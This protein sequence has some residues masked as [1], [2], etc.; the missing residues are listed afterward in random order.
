MTGATLDPLAEAADWHVILNDDGVSEADL[1]R[2]RRWLAQSPANASA[3][4]QV[5]AVNRRFAMLQS[6][7]RLDASEAGLRA[8]L[9][10]VSDRRRM[11]MGLAGVG[12][13][14]ALGWSLW[15]DRQRRDIL[16]ARMADERTGTGEL[17]EL[18]LAR[19]GRVWLNS[20]TA[21]DVDG[22]GRLR[23][24]TGE[25]QVLAMVMDTPLRT[26]SRHG[27]IETRGGRFN[28][29]LDGDA[30]RLDVLE[31][32]ALVAIGEDRRLVRSGR[33]LTLTADGYGA[34]SAANADLVAWT[35][36][37]LIARHM[38]LLTLVG[39]LARHS[40]HQLTL[41]PAVANIEIM[42]VYPLQNVDAALDML[43]DA[44]PISI[45]RDRA[46]RI[47]IGPA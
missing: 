42:G 37:M 11:L 36:G 1:S 9:G 31:G 22:G 20:D 43:E 10:A 4:S 44:L 26:E 40:R 47:Y 23:L 28:L 35:R 27:L 5:E 30:S 6:H 34:E 41:S 18:A 29:R 14:G 15:P 39:Q 17:R 38:P 16:L 33:A 2:W 19:G 12:L 8:V 7:G 32:A 21:L 46:G 45:K 24:F 25:I 3:W 13:C